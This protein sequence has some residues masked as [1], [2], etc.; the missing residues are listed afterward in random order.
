MSPTH[1]PMSHPGGA[2]KELSMPEKMH[3]QN[4]HG[5]IKYAIYAK[6]QA[7]KKAC[8]N[9]LLK[10]LF[11]KEKIPNFFLQTYYNFHQSLKC[12]A[13]LLLLVEIG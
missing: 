7:L 12:H 6:I 4:F 13:I 2:S 10:I 9:Q 11:E 5:H 3:T 8:K 1:S